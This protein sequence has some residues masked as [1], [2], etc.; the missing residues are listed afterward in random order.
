MISFA[1]ESGGQHL[2]ELHD[3]QVPVPLITGN[4]LL[5]NRF[6]DGSNSLGE[7][8]GLAITQSELDPNKTESGL[9]P[10]SNSKDNTNPSNLKG[11]EEKSSDGI[12]LSVTIKEDKACKEAVW[13]GDKDTDA[14]SLTHCRHPYLRPPG[15]ASVRLTEQSLCQNRE[16]QKNHQVPLISYMIFS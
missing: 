3:N 13:S 9:N 15:T 8:Q 7:N 5:W 6:S 14:K 16:W 2:I 10:H 12:K 1:K 4:K 11:K